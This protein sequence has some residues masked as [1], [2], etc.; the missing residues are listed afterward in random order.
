MTTIAAA[1]KG[2][3]M[4]DK[5]K[6]AAIIEKAGYLSQYPG[7][8]ARILIENGVTVP[9]RGHWIIRSSGKGANAT[10]WAECSYCHVCGSP[11]WKVCPV[12]ETKMDDVKNN[13]FDP[14][15]FLGEYE[16]END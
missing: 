4:T 7:T 10:N 5:E 13:N 15:D 3:L 11:Q 12:C 2:K 6:I 16:D 8:M 1:E 9:N 14:D